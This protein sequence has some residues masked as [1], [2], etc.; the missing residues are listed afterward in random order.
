MATNTTKTFRNY[1]HVI[2]GLTASYCLVQLLNIKDFHDW[3]YY[4][5]SMLLGAFIGLIC[6]LVWDVL[7]MK[8]MF[9]E[10]ADAKDIMRT[11]YG[12]I[13]GGIIA[14]FFKEIWLIDTFLLYACAAGALAD[15]VRAKIQMK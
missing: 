5:L 13:F 6:G 10:P 3:Q 7:I 14:M 11:M 12:G 1:I 9:K 2:G 4:G 15:I 8:F